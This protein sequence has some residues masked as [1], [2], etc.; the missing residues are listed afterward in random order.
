MQVNDNKE[1]EPATGVRM[2]VRIFQEQT[3]STILRT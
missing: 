3:V 2:Q 1:F